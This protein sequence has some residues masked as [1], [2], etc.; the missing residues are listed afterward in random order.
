[1]LCSKPRGGRLNVR[2]KIADKT[3]P[4]F[5]SK[6]RH[7][8]THE[9]PPQKPRQKLTPNR[10]GNRWVFTTNSTRIFMTYLPLNLPQK[11]MP[12]GGAFSA[13]FLGGEMANNLGRILGRRK[14]A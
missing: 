12:F 9:K 10:T 14:E 7:D 13:D 6:K 5:A 4:F 1:M 3:T 11:L 2:F 8:F